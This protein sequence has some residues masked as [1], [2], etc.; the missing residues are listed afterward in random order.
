MSVTTLNA[1]R[2]TATSAYQD[3]V[4]FTTADNIQEVGKAVMNAPQTVQNEFLS[5]LINK[6][7]LQLYNDRV[8]SN[9][10][11]DLKKGK[12]EYGMTIEDIFVEMAEAKQ[13]VRG[14]R[15]GE[16]PPDQ[17]SINKA[18]AET[19]FYSYTF[20]KQFKKT[21]HKN[22]LNRAFYS[23]GGVDRLVSS[24]MTS[25][26]NGENYADYRMTI[27]LVA[28]QIEQC[29]KDTDTKWKGAVHLLTDYNALNNTT[30]SAEDALQS[31]DFLQYMSNQIKK[32]SNRLTKPNKDLNPAGVTAWNPKNEQR[33]MMLGDIQSDLDTNLYAWAYNADR[34]EIG[35]IDEIDAW[36]SIGAEDDVINVNPQNI[37]VKAKLGTDGPCIGT[38]YNANMVKWYNKFVASTQSENAAGLY[39]NVFNTTGDLI[40]ASP[41]ENFVAFFL[42]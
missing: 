13:Y 38:I 26:V 28:R 9:P 21:I 10:L 20:E 12:M 29:T 41:F 40:A 42:D 31:R 6:V 36:Y 22:D 30:L 15:D 3:T 23:A 25:M 1:I 27:A 35:A 7:G 2:A 16:T 5:A 4:P 14:T 33:L 11:M 37:E 39:Y 17:F 8:F 34:L 32:W 24:V 19:G 18:I